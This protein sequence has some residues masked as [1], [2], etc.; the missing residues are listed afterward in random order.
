MKRLERAALLSSLG[1]ELIDNG[2]WCGETHLQKAVYLLQEV[3]TVPTAFDFV[4]YKFGPFSFPE[5]PYGPRLIPTERSGQLEKQFS[6]AVSEFYGPVSFCAQRLGS[7]GVAELEKLATA[8]YVTREYG[9]DLKAK[10]RARRL[11]EL[12]PHI[13]SRDALD[14]IV[15]IDELL[16]EVEKKPA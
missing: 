1:R 2:S 4:L 7:L 10:Q 8:L 12:K 11:S 16:A 5:Q 6:K 14:A 3:F 13:D 9:K 15:A